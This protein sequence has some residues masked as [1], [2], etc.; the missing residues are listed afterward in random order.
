ME[1]DSEHPGARLLW[2]Q[3][4]IA[5]THS[6][7]TALASGR[8]RIVLRGHCGSGAGSLEI[9]ECGSPEGSSIA[10]LDAEACR[11]GPGHT[12]LGIGRRAKVAVFVNA[13]RHRDLQ[14][15]ESGA[16]IRVAHQ[17]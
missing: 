3:I 17:G 9:G 13:A 5:R 8:F 2:P 15:V 16:A 11:R 12:D 4:R 1:V 7:A 6:E 14:A 10:P